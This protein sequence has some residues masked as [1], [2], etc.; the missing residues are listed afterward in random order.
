MDTHSTP[1]IATGLAYS[2]SGCGGVLPIEA[3]IMPGQGQLKLTGKN[4]IK[5]R[6]RSLN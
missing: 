2:Q 4:K 3:N 1:G 5:Q 6:K